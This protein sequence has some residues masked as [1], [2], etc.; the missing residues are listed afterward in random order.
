LAFDLFYPV[1]YSLWKEITC[2]IKQFCPFVK[3]LQKENLKKMASIYSFDLTN[4]K[5]GAILKS[6]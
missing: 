3:D 4:Y 2:I 5:D 6:I 1:D